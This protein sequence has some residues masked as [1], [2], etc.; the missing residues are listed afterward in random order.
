MIMLGEASPSA[1]D[2]YARGIKQLV[3]VHGVG[4]WSLISH[5][6][7]TMRSEEWGL[8]KE[9]LDRQEVSEQPA[10]FRKRP[11]EHLIAAS[12]F[13]APPLA[14]Q[15]F[16]YLRVTA[17]LTTSSK[18]PVAAIVDDVDGLEPGSAASTVTNTPIAVERPSPQQPQPRGR[19]GA[20]RGRGTQKGAGKAPNPANA[21]GKGKASAK[22]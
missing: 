11:W 5:A 15:Q 9:D 10:L 3:T 21:K 7:D 19:G 2:A 4:A 8:L 14:C 20:G 1:L 13:G 16:W 18:R 12:A 6:D 22:R 17:P